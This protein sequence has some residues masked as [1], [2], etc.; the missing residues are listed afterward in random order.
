VENGRR[1][2]A[3][4]A[5]V[6]KYAYPND[7]QE[8]DRLDFLHAI[9]YKALGNKLFLAPLEQDK[10]KNA[11]DIGTGTGLW[12][13]DFG[14]Q[15]LNAKVIGV[16]LSP[17]QPQW[18]APNVHFFVENVEQPWSY[19]HKFDFI[20]GRYLISSFKDYGG[21]IRQA[22]ECLEPGG[23]IEFQDFDMVFKC[24]DG[25]LDPK[26]SMLKWSHSNIEATKKLAV[27]GNPGPKLSQWMKEAGL[28]NI[29]ERVVKFPVGGWPK[30]RK[31]KELG[32][33]FAIQMVDG[34][35]GFLLRMY[36]QALGWSPE[37]VQVFCVNLR[38]EIK[39]LST[40]AYVNAH[41]VYGQK[42]TA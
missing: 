25:T 16:D 9:F 18:V 4:Q 12:A 30:D 20:F 27:Q 7:E 42:P 31:L 6:A 39:N 37:E 2:H 15:F 5:E 28:V 10:V 3:Y 38:K 8:I 41:C 29:K 35:E 23:F 13:L 24:D 1:Y 26:S 11:M 34:L 22:T 17:I 14:D 19:S 36:T 21:V 33:L 40:H 32:Q